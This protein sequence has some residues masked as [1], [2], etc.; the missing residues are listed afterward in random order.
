MHS[1]SLTLSLISLQRATP[2][3]PFPLIVPGRSLLRRS[4][5]VKVDRGSDRRVR[6]VLLFSDCLLWISKGGEREDWGVWGEWAT[7][8]IGIGLGVG[9]D[10]LGSRNGSVLRDRSLDRSDNLTRRMKSPLPQ[11]LGIG[12]PPAPALSRRVVGR[13]RSRSDAD[14]M[15]TSL[16]PSVSAHTLSTPTSI[17]AIRSPKDDGDERWWYRGR[18]ELMDIEVVMAPLSSSPG[19]ERMFEVLSPE[20]SFELYAG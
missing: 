7:A 4:T 11:D 15:P 10:G 1:H 2:N 5:F 18:A 19:V 3:L 17:S 13:L 12:S 20:G 16:R 14:I 8:G 6:D 9:L